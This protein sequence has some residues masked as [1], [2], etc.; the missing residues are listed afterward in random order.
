ML[1]RSVLSCEVLLASSGLGPLASRNHL[2]PEVPS[3][4]R[5]LL[6]SESHAHNRCPAQQ[7]TPVLKHSYGGSGKKSP[8]YRLT[9][10]IRS[11]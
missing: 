7:H 8:D 3:R 6:G 9:V 5:R 1:G 11:L 2:S 4:M 10:L